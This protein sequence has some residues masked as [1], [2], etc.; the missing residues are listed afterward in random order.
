MPVRDRTHLNKL[1]HFVYEFYDRDGEPVYVGFTSNLPNRLLTHMGSEMWR[2]VVD[3]R[4][5]WHPDR[6]SAQD[7]EKQAI[8]ELRPRWNFQCTERA[9]EATREQHR[10]RREATA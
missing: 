9:S 5:T 6:D 2:E 3:V 8:R 1:P 4:A 7:A 10:R